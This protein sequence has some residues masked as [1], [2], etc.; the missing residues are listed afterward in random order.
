MLRSRHHVS[1]AMGFTLIAFASVLFNCTDT[2]LIPLPQPSTNTSGSPSPEHYVSQSDPFAPGVLGVGTISIRQTFDGAPFPMLIHAPRDQGNYPLVIFEHGF[3]ALNSYYDEILN[4]LASHGFVVIAPQVYLPSPSAFLG[5][6]TAQEEADRVQQVIAWASTH[7]QAIVGVGIRADLLGVTGHSRGAKVAY[8]L[9]SSSI[10][11][12]GAIAAVDPVDDLGGPARNQPAVI[13]GT[14]QFSMPALVIGTGLESN[15]APR[16]VN[17]V[18]FYE[19]TPAPAWH[20]VALQQGHTDMLD[21]AQADL[22]SLVCPSGPNHAAM[23]RLTAGL[24]TAFF[25][26]SLQGD[27]AA[28]D[29]LTDSSQYQMPVA[30]ESK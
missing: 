16:G 18:Q 14:F 25:R 17:H 2:N 30:M 10:Q 1:S 24:L 4:H 8:I 22:S 9:A 26:A 11:P 12:I 13:Q 20:I 19:A 23:R 7:L 28:Y 5:K 27:S 3:M 21:E 15:C 6:P 29:Y